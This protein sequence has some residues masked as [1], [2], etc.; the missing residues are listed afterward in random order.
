MV[1]GWERLPFKRECCSDSKLGRTAAAVASW[2]EGLLM[3]AINWESLLQRRLDRRDCCICQLRWNTTV[4]AG[5]KELVLWQL[6]ENCCHD[7]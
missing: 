2:V 6:T 3:Q 1:A 5:W 7:N 4:T